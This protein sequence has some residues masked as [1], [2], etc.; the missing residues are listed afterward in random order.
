MKLNKDMIINLLK[1]ESIDRLSKEDRQKLVVKLNT[2]FN[3]TER[4]IGE[5]L[6]R[7]HS[8]I[9]DWITGRQCGAGPLAH[10]SIDK[11]IMKLEGYK[12]RL[13]EFTKLEK[14]KKIIEGILEL[15]Y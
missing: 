10:I 6:G 5:L 11:M 13:A 8:T 9:H 15:R 3:M 12:P 4:E 1:V 2:Q 14:L 7:P